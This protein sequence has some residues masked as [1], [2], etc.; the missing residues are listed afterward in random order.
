MG[1]LTPTEIGTHYKIGLNLLSN[2][3]S[4]LKTEAAYVKN[5]DLS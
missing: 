1:V 5:S 2:L 4:T 3:M